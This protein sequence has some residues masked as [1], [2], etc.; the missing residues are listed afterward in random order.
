MDFGS[1]LDKAAM[2][3]LKEVDNAP[4]TQGPAATPS[5]QRRQ[6]S[7][8]SFDD[9]AYYCE[10]HGWTKETAGADFYSVIKAFNRAMSLPRMGLII[11]GDYGCGKTAFVKSCGLKFGSSIDLTIP[12]Q[13]EWIDNRGGYQ[14]SLVEMCERNVFLDDLGAENL[15]NDFGVKREICGEFI[16]RYHSLGKGRLFIT[17]NLRGEELLDRYGGRVVDRL[18]QLCIPVRMTGA[19]KRKWL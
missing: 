19:S 11:T 18:K 7:Y 4:E 17:T 5:E 12:E 9:V 1:A 2:G 15:V 3:L 6:L 16:C 10:T 8:K 14:S 13:L